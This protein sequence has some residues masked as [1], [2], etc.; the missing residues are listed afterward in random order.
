[1]LMRLSPQAGAVPAPRG[2][3]KSSESR[4]IAG[5]N[6]TIITSETPLGVSMNES[7]GNPLGFPIYYKGRIGPLVHTR[8]P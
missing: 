8:Q 5:S 4:G 7:E 2:P 6:Q 1:M 3:S